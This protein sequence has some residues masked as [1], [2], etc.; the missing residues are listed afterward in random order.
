MGGRKSVELSHINYTE[1]L[2]QCLAVVSE[3]TLYQL[4][5]FNSLLF[6]VMNTLVTIP[7]HTSAQM[8]KIALTSLM[9]FKQ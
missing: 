4:E 1:V 9:M 7:P 2:K 6:R 3:I 5:I 8:I